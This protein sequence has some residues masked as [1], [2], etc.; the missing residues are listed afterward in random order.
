MKCIKAIKENKYKIG[1][2]IRIG[3]IEAEER[4]ETGYWEYVPKSQWKEFL[5][6]KEEDVKISNKTEKPLKKNHKTNETDKK[7]KNLK[8][9]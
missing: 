8:K 5:K 1:E 2:I 3:D 4:V 7:T 9:K 6:P